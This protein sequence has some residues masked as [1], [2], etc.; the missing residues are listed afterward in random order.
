MNFYNGFD[1]IVAVVFDMSP[2]FGVLEPKAK[3]L[4]IYFFI[5][6]G[7]NSHN[8]TLELFGNEVNIFSWTMKQVRQTI[9][10]VNTSWNFHHWNK[11][12]STWL[13]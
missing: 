9:S 7:G 4:L 10:Q 3:E 2:Q 13:S 8:F 1:L 5:G 12:N 6:K 11:Y